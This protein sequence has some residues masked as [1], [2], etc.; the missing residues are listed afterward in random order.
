[1]K[2]DDWNQMAIQGLLADAERALALTDVDEARGNRQIVRDTM[3]SAHEI[4]IDLVRRSRWL[5]LGDGEQVTLQDRLD[6]LRAKLHFFGVS[7]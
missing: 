3:T 4:Y 1:M 2:I 5:I 6:C 7:I